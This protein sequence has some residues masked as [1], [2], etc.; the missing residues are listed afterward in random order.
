MA[1]ASV[2]L[3]AACSGDD[4]GD[5]GAPPPATGCAADDRKDIYTAGL[6]KPAGAL[7]VKLVDATPGPPIKGTNAMTIEVLD[8]GGQPVDGATVTVTPWMPDHA[9]GSAVKP[10]VTGL[11][12]GKYTVEKVYLAMAGLWQIKIAVQPAGGGPLQEAT[13][14]FCL[15]G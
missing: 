8:A 6:S 2:V 14:Q 9:H 5:S 3:S 13:F 10:V 12:G 7:S 1:L 15:D 4:D 11:G